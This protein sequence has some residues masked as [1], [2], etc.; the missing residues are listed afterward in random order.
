MSGMPLFMGG[1]AMHTA[2]C[3]S[4]CMSHVVAPAPQHGTHCGTC[5]L[6]CVPHHRPH[7]GVPT[8]L[9][10]KGEQSQ[11]TARPLHNIT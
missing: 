6:V 3:M 2:S 8:C 9:S 11:K 10:I 4:I 7:Q 5:P 1:Q